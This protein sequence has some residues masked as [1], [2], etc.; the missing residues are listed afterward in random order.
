MTRMYHIA[1]IDY[2]INTIVNFVI[3]VDETSI[4]WEKIAVYQIRI[5]GFK[6][7]IPNPCINEFNFFWSSSIDSFCPLSLRNNIPKINKKKLPQN[8]MVLKDY[9]AQAMH[10]D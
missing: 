9:T 7:L 6:I 5:L 1:S 3:L 2:A 4:N 10:C 8:W